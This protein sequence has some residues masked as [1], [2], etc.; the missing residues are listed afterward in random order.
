VVEREDKADPLF[1]CSVANPTKE[2]VKVVIVVEL[3]VILK[4]RR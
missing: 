3:V 1:L 2:R 4:R